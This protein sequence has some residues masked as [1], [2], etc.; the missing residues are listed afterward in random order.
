MRTALVVVQVALTVSVVAATVL[1]MR[2][3]GN[4]AT[5]TFGMNL[6]NVLVVNMD[7]RSANYPQA[8][9]ERVFSEMSD[10]VR[11]LP[12]VTHV[13]TSLSVPIGTGRYY[14]A[15]TVPGH[16]SPW[17]PHKQGPFFEAVSPE[18]F[19]LLGIPIVE[20]RTFE[21]PT[22]A[23][24]HLSSLSTRK[25][26]AMSSGERVHSASVFSFDWSRAADR[27]W[28]S[29]APFGTGSFGLPASTMARRIRRSTCPRPRSRTALRVTS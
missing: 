13:S 7:L 16:K 22:T 10:E 5:V 15:A 23:A 14:V 20:G 29:F 4:A 21:N 18:Y 12:Q 8:T 11:R 27:S 24:V 26:L 2:S 3:F 28:G 9:I 19:D 17:G 6:D 1:F 25:R